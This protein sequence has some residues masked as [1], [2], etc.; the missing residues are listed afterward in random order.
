MKKLF[1]F[2]LTVLVAMGVSGCGK[3]NKTG[4]KNKTVPAGTTVNTS[5]NPA[6]FANYDQLRSYYESYSMS[7][8]LS[9]NMVVYHI[10]PIYGG[11]NLF[12]SYN[13]FNFDLDFG[14]CIN[15]FGTLKGDCGSNQS[16]N[17]SSSL[18]YFIERGEYKI[19]RGHA[20]NNVNYDRITKSSN[21]GNDFQ[22]EQ[23]D[24]NN[25]VYREML[26]LSGD[27]VD[28]IVITKAD[29]QVSERDSN[30]NFKTDS[31]GNLIVKTIKADYVEYFFTNKPMEGYVISNELPLVANPIARTREHEF[32]GALSFA[33]IYNISYIKVDTHRLQF[34]AFS[35]DYQIIDRGPQEVVLPRL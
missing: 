11:D 20:E 8:R 22:A 6:N 28:K 4:S 7:T 17:N 29:V 25:E 9:S 27:P 31:N 14:Y 10:G 32:I 1:G 26:N 12:N 16:S 30:G 2:T 23:Y 21:A 3:D 13:D 15:L 33:D 34:N 18:S 19:I 5:N 35:A 24:R